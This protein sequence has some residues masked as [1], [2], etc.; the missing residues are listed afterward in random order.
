M[1]GK[2]TF[3]VT[4]ASPERTGETLNASIYVCG[5][6]EASLKALL[7]V[8]QCSI[9]RKSDKIM[10]KLERQANRKGKG[11]DLD[12]EWLINH[13]ADG[14]ELLA[15]KMLSLCPLQSSSNVANSSTAREK[16]SVLITYP[17][18]SVFLDFML[19]SMLLSMR[20]MIQIHSSYSS[21]R[22]SIVWSIQLKAMWSTTAAVLHTKAVWI[23]SLC[24]QR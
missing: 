14:L 6:Y 7:L 21:W 8:V 17:I 15:G 20:S 19:L 16:T 2:V 11:V 1:T 18:L 3:I 13:Q 9:V 22:I 5:C 4:T 23:S 10:K 12:L 24:K